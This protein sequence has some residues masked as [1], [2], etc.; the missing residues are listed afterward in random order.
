MTEKRLKKLFGFESV[1]FKSKSSAHQTV[2]ARKML[3]QISF[4]VCYTNDEATGPELLLC[5]K[6]KNNE[7]ILCFTFK[8]NLLSNNV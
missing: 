7:R 1:Y 4:R 3:I 8:R 2:E 5:I 6:C